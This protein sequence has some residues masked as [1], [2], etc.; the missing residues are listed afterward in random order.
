[1]PRKIHPDG[2]IITNKY[3][4]EYI[5]K[6]GKWVYVKKP[7]REK[8]IKPSKKVEYNYPEIVLP[9]NIKESPYPG[10]YVSECGDVYRK[11]GKTDRLR[12]YG[13][14]NEYGLIKMKPGSRGNP[15]NKK[16]HYPCH[17]IS[18]YDE[19]STV[20]KQIKKSVHQLVAETFIPNPE[21]Y[22][23]I[24]HIDRNKNNNH[25]N[26]LRW[27]DRTEN[28]KW[29]KDEYVKYFKFID[30][31][32]NKVYEGGNFQKFLRENWD[33]IS[34]RTRVKSPKKFSS[35]FYIGKI[36]NGFILER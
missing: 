28:M 32:T 18:V 4:Y 20:T 22:K 8:I 6:D 17:N 21:N 7:K 13:E 12:Q 19:N 16:Y 34:K 30:T 5:K 24:D 2:T 9:D 3:G 1:M 35:Y 11:P 27:C 26:N 10:Y 36:C 25:V 14:I 29:I 33:W 23:E 31:T 15:R